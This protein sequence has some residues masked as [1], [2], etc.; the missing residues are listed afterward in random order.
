MKIV[1]SF[2]VLVALLL[3]V[4]ACIEPYEPPLDDADVNYL[5]VDGFLDATAGV[6]TVSLS[7]T[8]PVTS[9]QLFERESGATVHIEDGAGIIFPLAETDR[10]KYTG[11]VSNAATD[12]RYR[13]QIRTASNRAYVSDFVAI[14]QT[15]PIDSITWA[16]AADGVQF[17]VTTH[18]PT[19][20]SRFYRWKYTETYEYNSTFNSLYR[21]ENDQPVSRRPEESIFTCWTTNESTD[22][23]VGSTKQLHEAV[24]Y[25]SPVMFIPAGSVKVS[26]RYSLLVK[27]H[28]ISEEAYQYWLS[29]EKSTEN[30][31]G[32]FD[33][34]PSEAVGNIHGQTDPGETVIGYFNAGTVEEKRLFVRRNELPVEI[35]WNSSGIH[36]CMRDTVYLADLDQVYQ[37]TTLIL[38]AIYN[39][40]LIGYTTSEAACADCRVL[41]GTTTRPPFWD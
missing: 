32:L 19:G 29:L 6:A 28:A 27:Q 16:V 31:G 18:D 26:R 20:R 22:I 35:T 10:G 36:G 9:E 40:L 39:P 3:A 5:V 24:I 37:P 25:K 13:L 21:F 11:I 41:G 33:P 17:S 2:T 30:L 12:Q 7:R 8:L 23:K 34:L 15:P 38:D 4:N 1:R 14:I